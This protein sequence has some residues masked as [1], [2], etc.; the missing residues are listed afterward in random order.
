MG[1][2]FRSTAHSPRATGNRPGGSR[3]YLP[4]C[5]RAKYAWQRCGTV[6]AYESADSNDEQ[7]KTPLVSGDFSSQEVLS[8]TRAWGI[9]GSVPQAQ[10]SRGASWALM[11][12]RSATRHERWPA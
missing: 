8:E 2:P 12:V 9:D 10:H 11:E 1:K 3:N 5:K 4:L 6:D 7:E